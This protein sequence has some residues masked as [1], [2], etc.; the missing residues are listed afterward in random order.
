MGQQIEAL[1]ASIA[2]LKAGQEQM[3]QQISR[4]IVKNAVARTAEGK[5]SE[6]RTAEPRSRLSA[7]PPRPAPVRKPRPVYSPAPSAAAY[8]V[9]PPAT[10][11][12]PAQPQVTTDPDGNLV[13]RPPMPLR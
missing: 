1:K 3:A 13:V 2:Q 4:D 12:M 10:A 7:L 5:S 6:T 8:D 11:P 9:P